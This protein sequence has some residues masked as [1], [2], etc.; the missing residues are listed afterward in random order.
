MKAYNLLTII[1]LGGV[2]LFSCTKADYNDTV[3]KGNPPPVP[4]GFVNSSDVAT[5]NLIAYWDFNNNKNETK[6]NT[7]PV[8]DVNSSYEKGIKGNALH[9][10]S[11]YLLF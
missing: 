3:T 2:L 11:G 7:A 8:L 6:S 9:L 1:A 5:S 10:S 4:G